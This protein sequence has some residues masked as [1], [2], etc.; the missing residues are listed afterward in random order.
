V[1]KFPATTATSSMSARTG[2]L[3]D[4]RLSASLIRES[5]G[6]ASLLHLSNEDIREGKRA[7]R[8]L[9]ER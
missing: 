1:V 6:N 4:V 3:F 7:E 8:A 2:R 9:K 5:R